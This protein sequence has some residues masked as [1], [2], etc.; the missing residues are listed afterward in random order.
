MSDKALALLEQV[1]D[2]TLCRDQLPF[3][4]RPVLQYHPDARILI[5]GQAPGRKAHELCRPFDDVSGNRLRDWLGV[6]REQFYN[7]ALFALVPMGFCYPGKGKSGDLPP[8]PECAATWRDQLLAELPRI[9]MTLVLG[10]YAL[11]YHFGRQ[12]GTLAEQVKNWRDTWPQQVPLPHPSPRNIG[13]LQRNLWFE[14]ELL[15][16]IKQRVE[17]LI[18]P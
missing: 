15:P 7:P 9:Q 8:R 17:E 6:T 10:Q 12:R 2:C 14:A 1:R 5:A 4:P 13:W 18:R 16:K 3:V 11:A